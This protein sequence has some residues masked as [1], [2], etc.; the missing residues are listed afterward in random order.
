MERLTE[1]YGDRYI[2]IKGCNSFYPREER[3]SAPASNAVIRLAAYEDKGL[4]PQD[5]PTGVEMAQIAMIL[6]MLNSSGLTPADLLRAA[7]LVKAEK[8]G[9]CV[10]LPCKAGDTVW[11][12]FAM[13]GWYFRDKDK[14]YAAKIV[15]VGLNSSEE[16]GG[17]FFNVVYGKH[18]HMMQ[19]NF[20]DIGKTVFLTAAE[21]KAALQKGAAHDGD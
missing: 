6:Q 14:P 19:F 21:A 12:N 16:M 11:T 9:R 7:E 2:R 3:K 1:H 18:D 8:E 17:G 15:F 20:S 13:T 10:V 4:A 5:I